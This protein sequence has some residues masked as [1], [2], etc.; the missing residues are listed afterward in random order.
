MNIDEAKCFLLARQN[1]PALQQKILQ[2]EV[3]EAFKVLWDSNPSEDEFD[4]YMDRILLTPRMLHYMIVPRRR[5][6]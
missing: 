2:K 1:E 5:Q 6:E 4:T 3:E